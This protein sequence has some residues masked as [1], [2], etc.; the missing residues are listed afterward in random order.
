MS[1]GGRVTFRGNDPVAA[2]AATVSESTPTKCQARTRVYQNGAL[3]AE[4]FPVADIS[5]YLKED[6]TRRL[7]RPA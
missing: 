1:A 4:G 6:S 7:A 3:A 2:A 5:E